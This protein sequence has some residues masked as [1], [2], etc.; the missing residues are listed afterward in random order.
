MLL[1]LY[2]H[3]YLKRNVIVPKQT[4]DDFANKIDTFLQSE[5]ALN[6][7]A[8]NT[9]KDITSYE[10]NRNAFLLIYN[11]TFMPYIR[12]VVNTI[13]DK[14]GWEITEIYSSEHFASDPMKLIENQVYVEKFRRV[15]EDKIF[16]FL[17][18]YLEQQEQR[19]KLLTENKIRERELTI[20]VNGET[21]LAEDSV[22]IDEDTYYI[23]EK[24]NKKHIVLRNRIISKAE[25]TEIRKMYS[26]IANK[27]KFFDDQIF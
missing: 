25:F 16:N 9:N 6:F 11:E 23:I 5:I 1:W 19:V 8:H 26:A 17:Q 7:I 18:T 27:L 4:I 21:I 13:R 2:L 24:D 14:A 20:T 3:K 10:S 22:Y 15:Y 12:K